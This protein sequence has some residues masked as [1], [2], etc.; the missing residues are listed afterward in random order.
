MILRLIK[1][2]SF[3]HYRMAIN[4]LPNSFRNHWWLLARS[5]FILNLAKWSFSS[6]I[7]PYLF[8]RFLLYISV[9]MINISTTLIM[10][11]PSQKTKDYYLKHGNDF[12][13]GN[14]EETSRFSIVLCWKIATTT[15]WFSS[16][17]HINILS[18]R[19]TIWDTS[20]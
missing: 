13:V 8:V 4:Y 11:L 15:S 18:K 10:F 9:N 6:S 2:F 1:R 14:K 3:I 20:I 5:V 7:I 12:E 19:T 16:L 17:E